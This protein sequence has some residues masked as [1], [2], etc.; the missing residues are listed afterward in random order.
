M[1]SRILAP[2]I[3]LNLALAGAAER[4]GQL[5]ALL[6]ADALRALDRLGALPRLVVQDDGQRR[7]YSLRRSGFSD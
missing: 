4:D 3:L 5:Q 7:S 1:K 2:S 6:G